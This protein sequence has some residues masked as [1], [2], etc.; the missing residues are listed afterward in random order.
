LNIQTERLENHTARLTVHV[1]AGRFDSTKKEAAR[2]ISK[3]VNIP[4][5]RRG[6]APYKILVNYIGE[7]AI[8]EDAVEILAQQLYATA[9][10]ESKLN[11]YGPGS[12]EDFSPEPPTLT[13]V[14][15]LEPET[16]LGD[17][18]SVRQEFTAPQ[19]EDAD[20]DRAIEEYREQY[21][22]IEEGSKPVALGNRLT[23][24]IHAVLVKDEDA[25]EEAETDEA[26]AHAAAESTEP[27]EVETSDADDADADDDD[28][29]D[30][31]DHSHF[32]DD[33]N[34]L[35]HR[36][37]SVVILNDTHPEFAPGFN[38][39]LVGATVG[40]TR[41]F[42][43]DF[44]DDAEKY[45]MLAGEQGKF[46]VTV[47]KIE[48][49]TLPALNDDFAA[50]VTADEK[51]EDGEPKTL[52]LLELRMR[53]RENLR[54]EA[55]SRTSET[56]FSQILEEM[57]AGATIAYPEEMVKDQIGSRLQY[58]DQE[59]RR[60]GLNLDDYMR[61]MN[62][63]REDLEADYWDA[64]VRDLEQG[65]VIRQLI[66]NE[67]ITVDDSVIDEEITSLV[68]RYGDQAESMRSLFSTP[69]MRQNLQSELLNR[70]AVERVI[71]IAKGE[72]PEIEVVEET[73][74]GNADA[75]TAEAEP[76]AQDVE[77]PKNTVEESTQEGDVS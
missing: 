39:A 60:Q 28:A 77:L 72:A 55:E 40:E 74:S 46:S 73:E 12:L 1:D 8:I 75:T 15:P 22:V 37:D 65:L 49:M 17:Y 5:F 33:D 67:K 59:L 51:G 76:S 56:Y 10:E 58:L 66:Q 38:D 30:E 41:E 57:V 19:V 7:A 24:D 26:E 2:K 54:K 69:A 36:H 32:E 20:V 47:K 64:A 25:G 9:L 62:K 43:L 71:A 63:S 31:D 16:D 35:L 13:F 4:G 27:A 48:T 68:S 29:D 21:S 53:V 34:V 50:R 23:V 45:E 6:K 61:I 18:R 42:V 14:L 52:T 3:K 70:R 44:P 11:P